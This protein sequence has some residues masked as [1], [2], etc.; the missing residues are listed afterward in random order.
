MDPEASLLYSQRLSLPLRQTVQNPLPYFPKI[1]I[2]L[3][4]KIL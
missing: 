1:N 4:T 2:N 3:L